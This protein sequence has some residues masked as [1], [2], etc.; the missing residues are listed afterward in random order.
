MR[1]LKGS[2]RWA[3]P[4]DYPFEEGILIGRWPAAAG[5]R[6]GALLS[7]G[8]KNPA[9]DYG[10]GDF[11]RYPGDRHLITFGNTGSGKT[12]GS[13]IPNLL[14]FSGSALV[15]DPKGEIYAATAEK[16][17]AIGQRIIVLDPAQISRG[18]VDS[19]GPL[20][21][22]QTLDDRTMLLAEVVSEAIVIPHGGQNDRFFEDEAR[23]LLRALILSIVARSR[24][25][26]PDLRQLKELAHLPSAEL[27]QWLAVTADRFPEVLSGSRAFASKEPRLRSDIL[28]YAHS[29]LRFLELRGIRQSLAPSNWSFALLRE[30]PTTVYLMPPLR[31]IGA[32]SYRHWTRLL[33]EMAI[34]QISGAV[35]QVR[36]LMMIDEFASLGHLAAFNKFF[37]DIRGSGVQLWPILQGISQLKGLYE[38][39]WESLINN[40][41]VVQFYGVGDNATAEYVS[42]LLGSKTEYDRHNW[43]PFPRTA[44]GRPLMTPDEVLSKGGDLGT[45]ILNGVSSS[46]LPVMFERIYPGREGNLIGSPDDELAPLGPLVFGDGGFE[47]GKLIDDVFRTRQSRPE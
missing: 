19:F 15:I 2:A 17:R 24:D 5:N 26:P 42:S 11:I 21:Q 12:T 27:Q 18:K 4:D 34:S 10:Q 40:A 35:G 16:R 7:N 37:A 43:F 31:D 25:S 30:S 33:I 36:V 8:L 45:A 46:N 1:N 20:A 6:T 9:V 23:A 29:A 44:V 38:K 47:T 13:V 22:C 14:S 3:T 39:D 41:G 32:E 28:A